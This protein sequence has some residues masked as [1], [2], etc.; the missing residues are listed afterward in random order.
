MSSL[1]DHGLI[2]TRAVEQVVA[3][4]SC[5]LCRLVLLCEGAEDPEHFIHLEEA[6]RAVAKATENL[7]AVA[8]K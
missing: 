6:G 7:A 3:P 8:S 5:H 2:R 4:I 1:F